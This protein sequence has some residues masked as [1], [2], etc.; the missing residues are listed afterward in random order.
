MHPKVYHQRIN[1][2]VLS[3]MNIIIALVVLTFE[4]NLFG[5]LFFVYIH[6]AVNVFLFIGIWLSHTQKALI[7]TTEAIENDK[8]I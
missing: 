5:I 3:A 8:N 7:L 6:C 4:L 2:I 1:L